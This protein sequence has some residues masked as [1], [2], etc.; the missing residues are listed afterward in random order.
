MRVE[1]TLFRCPLSKSRGG[2][3]HSNEDNSASGL[4]RVA[5]TRHP[6]FC[7]PLPF[8]SPSCLLLPFSPFTAAKRRTIP[9]IPSIAA[10]FP[11]PSSLSY[12][13]TFFLPSPSMVIG[14]QMPPALN[15]SAIFRTITHYTAEYEGGMEYRIPPLQL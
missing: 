13:D 4:S 8:F 15:D 7:S 3:S 12:R 11:T 5:Y 1:T 9:P 6:F 14:R 10:V 2:E